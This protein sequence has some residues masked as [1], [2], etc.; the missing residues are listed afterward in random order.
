MS[1]GLTYYL[2][3][4]SVDYPSPNPSRYFC[5]KPFKSSL[6]KSDMDGGDGG[7]KKRVCLVF[8]NQQA[9]S[10]F[11]VCCCS[12]WW[13]LINGG[14]SPLDNIFALK[15]SLP[16]LHHQQCHCMLTCLC[17]SLLRSVW[18]NDTVVVE[19]R[20][21]FW[22]SRIVCHVLHER[23]SNVHVNKMITLPYYRHHFWT[24]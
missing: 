2:V 23:D 9:S 11:V 15:R 22:R 24:W 21:F 3:A 8:E 19:Q 17:T 1:P 12:L 13:H 4:F 14:L 5:P 6:Y 7:G 16:P 18:M 10:V 20:V